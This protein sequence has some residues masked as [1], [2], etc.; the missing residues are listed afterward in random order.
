MHLRCG[1]REDLPYVADIASAAFWDDEIVEFLAPYRNA[2]PLSHRASYLY[3][4][5]R[6]FYAG[7]SLV[8]AVTDSQDPHWTGKE[9][10]I[11]FA[12]WSDTQDNILA[13]AKP[14]TM[15]GKGMK[16]TATVELSN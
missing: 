6:H 1:R 16:R 8:V 2:F 13:Q 4:I 3:R 12:V 7:E 15:L 10:I 14:C 9:V 5:K 11:G